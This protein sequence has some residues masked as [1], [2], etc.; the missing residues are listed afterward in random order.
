MGSGFFK[1]HNIRYT[2]IPKETKNASLQVLQKK[3]FESELQS[4]EFEKL[5]RTGRNEC[6]GSSPPLLIHTLHRYCIC[7]I[8]NPPKAPNKRSP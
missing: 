4:F 2:A 8:S 5:K 1:Q 6:T 7:S 3:C